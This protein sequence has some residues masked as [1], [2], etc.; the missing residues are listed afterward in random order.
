LEKNEVHP[1]GLLR[2][3]IPAAGGRLVVAI[4]ILIT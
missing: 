3:T 1:K 4:R 2:I